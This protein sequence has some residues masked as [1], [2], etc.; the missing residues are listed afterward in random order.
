MNDATFA[1][2]Q[3]VV[4]RCLQPVHVSAVRKASR[5]EELLAHVLG[6]FEVEYG[7]YGD[8]SRALKETLRRFGDPAALSD[9]LQASTTAAGYVGWLRDHFIFTVMGYRMLNHNRLYNIFVATL[10]VYCLCSVSFVL[11]LLG[12]PHDARPHILVP[13]WSLPF[14]AVINGF[15][16]LAMTVTLTVRLTKPK[17]GNRIT[18]VMNWLFLIAPPFGTALGAYGLWKADQEQGAAVASSRTA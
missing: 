10:A 9:E 17:I 18:T 12:M 2:L 13:Q 7:K 4:E 3:E 11:F 8:E 15:Y 5:R 14:L 16:L 1:Q 6:V